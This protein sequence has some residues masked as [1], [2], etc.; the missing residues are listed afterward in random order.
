MTPSATDHEATASQFKRGPLMADIRNTSKTGSADIASTVRPIRMVG[1]DVSV[2]ILAHDEY[3]DRFTN[4]VF[5]SMSYIWGASHFT[6]PLPFTADELKSYFITALHCRVARVTRAYRTEVPYEGW[7]LPAPFATVVAGIGEI[8]IEVP[9]TRITPVFNDE[10]RPQLLGRNAW[11][12]LTMR[13]ASTSDHYTKFMFVDTIERDRKGRSD[14]MALYPVM[15]AVLAP[16]TDI[17]NDVPTVKDPVLTGRRI[18]AIVSRNEQIDAVSA[19]IALISGLVPEGW[20][21]LSRVHPFFM[22]AYSLGV[23]AAEL[24]IDRLGEVKGA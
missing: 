4:Q 8:S 6:S 5:R 24:V 18:T 19:A 1:G 15:E 16:A 23:E 12:D 7:A 20:D 2:M 21:D 17:V 13:I 11:Y 3:M 14:V 22:P 9:L 10:Y